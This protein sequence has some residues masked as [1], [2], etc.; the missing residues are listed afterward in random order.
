[1]EIKLNGM[2]WCQAVEPYSMTVYNFYFDEGR[3]KR[4]LCCDYVSEKIKFDD[5][6]IPGKREKISSERFE[7]A[8]EI[9]C[10]TS[11]PEEIMEF[12][13]QLNE[14]ERLKKI[15]HQVLSKC[16]Y[17]ASETVHT[18]NKVIWE[19]ERKK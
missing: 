2:L 17:Q 3:L 12:F 11:N 19:L 15:A 18:L 9:F 6:V 10:N 14:D 5:V 13:E 1:M 16:S 8:F 7:K 4:L